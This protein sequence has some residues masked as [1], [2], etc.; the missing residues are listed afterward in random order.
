[1]PKLNQPSE[2]EKSVRDAATVPEPDAEFVHS[3]RARFI[4]EGH[5][6]ANKNQET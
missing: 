6:S 5:A 1:M 3:L 2:L 4:T